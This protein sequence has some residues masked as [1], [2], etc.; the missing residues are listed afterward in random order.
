MKGLW[1][2]LYPF[3][4]FLIGLKCFSKWKIKKKKTTWEAKWHD[5]WPLP[6]RSVIPAP[7][8]RQYL[9]H[10]DLQDRGVQI[11]P[12]LEPSNWKVRCRTLFPLSIDTYWHVEKNSGEVSELCAN[13]H[14]TFWGHSW[15][16]TVLGEFLLS[17]VKK[18]FLD[19]VME[20]VV[21][22]VGEAGQE[23]ELELSTSWADLR[24]KQIPG[25]GY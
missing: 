4:D 25:L 6:F 3:P 2:V 14:N 16:T 13:S 1:E 18:T 12:D 23:G 5:N 21:S 22:K 17:Q 15:G 10:I 9:L 7:R 11:Q 8:P 24:S 20:E 19:E